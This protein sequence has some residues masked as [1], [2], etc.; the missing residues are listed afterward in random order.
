MLDDG[1][2]VFVAGT[3]PG[4]RVRV[5]VDPRGGRFAR[6]ALVSVLEPSEERVAPPCPQVD[7]CG[8]CDLMH[9]SPRARLELQRRHAE[10]LLAGLGPA[11]RAVP[12][13]QHRPAPELA[14]RSRA[15]LSI[16][17][18]RRAARVGYRAGRSHGLVPIET[19]PVLRAELAG[20]PATLA[21]LLADSTG[22]GQA[23]IALGNERQPVGSIRWE[24]VLAAAV[25]GRAADLVASGRWSG[26]ELWPEGAREPARYGDPRP[27]VPGP[28]DRTLAM[29]AG[30]F[31]QPSDEGGAALAGHVATLLEPSDAVVELFAGSGTLSA[32]IADRV[33]K[34]VAVESDPGAVAALRANLA[35][36]ESVTRVVLADANAYR[37]PRSTTAVVLDPPRAGAREAVGNVIAARP[38]RVVYVSCHAAALA[39]D[40]EVLIQGGH[41]IDRVDLFDLFP[42]THH[43]EI[44]VQLSR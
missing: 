17:G 3:A 25:F 35:P 38:R 2:Q 7:R 4:E 41:A 33:G 13:E 23:R 37:I 1:G 30:G 40:L 44:V 16:E 31:A 39:R 24:G 32:A 43:V 12:I 5:R 18:G 22:R 6:G 10:K 15:R 11:D 20:T 26:I 21:A 9:L 8:G 36:Y 34:L 29:A 27:V 42:Q 14:Y 19:C 28:G